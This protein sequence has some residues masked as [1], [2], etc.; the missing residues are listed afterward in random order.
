MG[1][2]RGAA[3]GMMEHGAGGARDG[4]SNGLSGLPAGD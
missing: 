4:S 3:F 2:D 1:L